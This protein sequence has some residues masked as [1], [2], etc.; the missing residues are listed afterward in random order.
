MAT[1]D[2]TRQT[3]RGNVGTTRDRRVRRSARERLA[4]GAGRETGPAEGGPG[5][6]T[7]VLR[8][9][10]ADLLG[11]RDPDCSQDEDDEQLLHVTPLVGRDGA[12]VPMV[13]GGTTRSNRRPPAGAR[14]TLEV[15][16]VWWP[17][18]SSKRVGR[19]LPVRWVR[20]LPP[21]P[22]TQPAH[23]TGVIGLGESPG[24]RRRFGRA[25]ARRRGGRGRRC[26]PTGGAACSWPGPRSGGCAPG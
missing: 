11:H 12:R 6:V 4:E 26:R 23:P 25:G 9:G 24:G 17:P 7:L 1:Y 20:F 16:G 2:A 10:F 15:N 22:I 21:P 8:S 3:S 19:A 14:P 5:N 18:S 13:G